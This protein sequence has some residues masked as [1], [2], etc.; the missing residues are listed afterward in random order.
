MATGHRRSPAST[1][2]ARHQR[3]RRR[4]LDLAEG[5]TLVLNGDGSIDQV[6]DAGATSHSWSPTD[7][8]WPRMAIRFGL[9]PEA[10][11]TAPHRVVPREPGGFR[12]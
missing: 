4:T 2:V 11:T 1:P 8:E 3:F 12:P 6:D 9:H 10:A 5:G 7:A